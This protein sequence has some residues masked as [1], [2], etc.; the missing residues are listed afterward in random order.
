MSI[1]TIKTDVASYIEQIEEL[2]K[3]VEKLTFLLKNEK[4]E[5]SLLC[6]K[7]DCY[8]ERHKIFD[9]C[10]ECAPLEEIPIKKNDDS[11]LSGTI[12]FKFRSYC[13]AV[14]Y[15]D[16]YYSLDC[17]MGGYTIQYAG[18]EIYVINLEDAYIVRQESVKDKDI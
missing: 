7:R 9:Y 11:C 18:E 2:K 5:T 8:N 4:N 6:K 14:Y 16:M 1:D 3:K 15:N 12:K 13:Y 17:D 10:F